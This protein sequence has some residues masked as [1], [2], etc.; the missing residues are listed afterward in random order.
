MPNRKQWKAVL[1][2]ALVGMAMLLQLHGGLF[3][4]T[5]R[6]TALKIMFG[7]VFGFLAVAVAQDGGRDGR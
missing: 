5:S 3:F 1:A 2:M 7:L 4:E 6:L